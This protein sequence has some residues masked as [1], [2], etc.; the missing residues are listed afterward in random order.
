MRR[1][2]ANA[3]RTLAVLAAGAWLLLLS[4]PA[5][6][7]GKLSIAYMPHPIHEQQA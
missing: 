7:A 1:L 3:F 2:R 5:T 6:A 4:G